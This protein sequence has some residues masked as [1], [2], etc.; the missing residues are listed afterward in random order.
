MSRTA[1][2]KRNS[3]HCVVA[4]TRDC[5]SVEFQAE[6]FLRLADLI[7]HGTFRVRNVS[8]VSSHL[9]GSLEDAGFPNQQHHAR[10]LVDDDGV[11]R[12]A[13]EDSRDVRT[14]DAIHTGKVAADQDFST[15]LSGDSQ[16]CR[17]VFDLAVLVDMTRT[18]LKPAA[19]IKV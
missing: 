12:L 5:L 11:G 16:H 6:E 13:A 2:W 14:R 15:R 18:T 3:R 4:E 1:R 19:D 9:I 8:P 10:A 7:E 17:Q